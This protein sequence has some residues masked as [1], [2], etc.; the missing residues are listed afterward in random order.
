M[1]GD[2][3]NPTELVA[4]LINQ[5]RSFEEG[6]RLAQEAIDGSCTLLL[7]TDDC[8][9]AARDRLGRTPLAIGGKPEAVCATL[10]TCALAN[11]G[12]ETERFLGPGEI[13]RL[14]LEGIETVQPPGD[15]M[16]ICSFLWVYYGFPASTYEG[17][18]ARRC[19]IA[20]AA[21][22][23]RAD[24]V[25]VDV[26]AGIPTREPAMQSVRAPGR[27]SYQRPFVKYTP[28]WPRSFMPPDQQV[29]DLVA[30]MKLIPVSELIR[31]KR[32][33]FCEDSIVRG[34]QLK[35]TIKRL[36]ADG[37]LGSTCGRLPPRFSAAS[38]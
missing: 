32:L 2:A 16:Q 36:Y 26:V 17:S 29:R 10:E 33:L 23:A 38:S 35:G 13:V 18:T 4:T 34:T 31:G 1:S 21:A 3:I 12:Y 30:R 14:S 24:N 20:A 7:M 8:I 28:T 37:A 22:L 6:I 11:L 15:Q 25:E 5:G 19:G 27:V 9:Y